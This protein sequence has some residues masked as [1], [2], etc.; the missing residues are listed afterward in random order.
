MKYGDLNID[1]N[2]DLEK[3]INEDIIMTMNKINRK[4]L[5]ILNQLEQAEHDK[6]INYSLIANPI[7]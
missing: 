3:S 2:K 1:T 6:V 4:L 5:S 7:Y